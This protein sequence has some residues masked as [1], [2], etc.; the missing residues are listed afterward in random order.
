MNRIEQ[1]ARAYVRLTLACHQDGLRVPF[2]KPRV[3]QSTE[4]RLLQLCNQFTVCYYSCLVQNT[5]AAS[6][7]QTGCTW[8][9]ASRHLNCK[10]VLY[11]VF[12][13]KVVVDHVYLLNEQHEFCSDAPHACRRCEHGDVL[14]HSTAIE[15]GLERCTD[16]ADAADDKTLT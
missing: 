14:R 4:H 13:S 9:G 15:R 12:V 16:N 5:T 3:Y 2:E 10:E 6:K 1:S 11:N 8:C 7:H